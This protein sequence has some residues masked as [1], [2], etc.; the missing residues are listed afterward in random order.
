MSKVTILGNAVVVSSSMKF[1]DLLTIKKYRPD[2]LTLMGGKDNEEPVFCVDVGDG[3]CGEINNFGAYFCNT[4]NDSEKK[5]CITMCFADAGENIKEFVA[6]Q[7][8]SAIMNLNKLEQLLPN[9]LEEIKAEKAAIM[10][11]ITIAQ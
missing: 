6:D 2:A 4:T 10:Q 8:G 7:I 1:D 11:N 9:V 5:A 3:M